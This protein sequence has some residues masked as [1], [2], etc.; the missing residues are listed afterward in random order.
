[1][2]RGVGAVVAV[3]EPV[4]ETDE[5]R[6]EE[7]LTLNIHSDDN[8]AL[9]LLIGRR[10]E[11]LASLQLLVNLIVN[12][13]TGVRE[14]II[15]DAEGYRERREHNLRAMAVRVAE[16]VR[17]SGMPVMLEAMPP[18]ERR[19]IHMALAETVDIS[20]DGTGEG[21]QRRVVVSLKR[22]ARA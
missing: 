21:D 15:V 11:T 13:Q 8:Q 10:G 20:T 14:H 22:P 4:G 1:G 5:E 2:Q 19:I 17:R 3:S 12:K 16:Q 7:P 6:E 18:N 9:A